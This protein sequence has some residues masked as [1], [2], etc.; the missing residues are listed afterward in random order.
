[1]SPSNCCAA[2]FIVSS[3]PP[4]F[5]A[6][7]DTYYSDVLFLKQPLSS[8]DV[9]GVVQMREGVDTAWPGDGVVYFQRLGSRRAQ[10]RLS[11]LTATPEY[12]SMTIRNWSTTTRLVDLLT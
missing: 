10:S 8:A 11:R 4:G 3:A 12:K 1:M 5:G 6:R 2:R 9:M 7:P